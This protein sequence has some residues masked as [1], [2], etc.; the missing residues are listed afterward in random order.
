MIHPTA[1]GVILDV[2]V[3]P[4]AGRSGLDGTRDGAV[5]VRLTA[6][7]LDGAA[8][9]QLIEILSDALDI[10]KKNLT[11]IAGERSRQKRVLIKGVS[12]GAIGARLRPKTRT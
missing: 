3:I 2:R 10:P 1:D 5:L 9:A 12:A 4:R 8:N 11:L 7:P 6:P